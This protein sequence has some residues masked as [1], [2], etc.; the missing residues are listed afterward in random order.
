MEAVCKAVQARSRRGK[1]FSLI[2]VAEGVKVPS[3]DYAV[4]QRV[5]AGHDKI[6][7]GGIGMWLANEIEELT[8]VES[9]AVVLGHI[10]RGGTPTAHDRVLAT[11]FGHAALIQAVAGN[12]SV[13]VGLHGTEVV[14]VP[15]REVAGKQ[16][17][18]RPDCDYV[19]AA[20]GVGTS[21]GE[22]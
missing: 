19:R 14:P 9:R 3:G 18:V 22:E 11:R 16:R 21:F 2:V 13:M 1:R 15:L 17:L 12:F 7:L 8:S 10:Q 20:R 4:R 6:R 5:E